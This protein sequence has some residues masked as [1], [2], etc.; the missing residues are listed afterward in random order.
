MVRL[1][2]ICP[3]EIALRR[4]LPALCKLSDFKFVGVAVANEDEWFGE[5]KNRLSSEKTK[6]TI[7][8]EKL[9]ATIFIDNYG[10]KIFDSYTDI[11]NSDEIDAIYLPLPPALHFK[12]AKLTLLSGKHILVEK[13]ATTTL[14]DTKELISYAKKNKLAFHENYMFAFHNQLIAINNIVESGEIGDVRLYRISFGFPRRDVNDFRY[15]KNLGGG[16]ILDCGGYTIKYA[17]MLLGETA[18]LTYSKCNYINEFDVDIY[19][20]AAMINE[21][22]TTVQLAFGMDNSYKCDLEVWGSKGCLLTERVLTAPSGF[23]PEL[24]LKKEN[25]CTTQQ[26]PTDDAFTKSI[27]KFE[28]CIQ[29]DNVRENNYASILRQA[30]LIDDFLKQSNKK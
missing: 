24:I 6:K 2:I 19:G 23:I 21:F 9:K 14:K 5:E 22:G 27:Q 26:L 18:K 3:S 8:N 12:W 4:F 1:G 17:S 30:E 10:G 28:E 11:I 29:K 16:A 7:D 20:S 25:E 13:P 15:N